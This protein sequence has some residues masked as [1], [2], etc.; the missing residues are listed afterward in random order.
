MTE[1]GGTIASGGAIDF[2]RYSRGLITSSNLHR[3]KALLGGALYLG[4]MANVRV[5]NSTIANNTAQFG[6]AASTVFSTLELSKTN[7]THNNSTWKHGTTLDIHSGL[8]VI[9]DCIFNDNEYVDG[10]IDIGCNGKAN[11]TGLIHLINNNINATSVGDLTQE[12]SYVNGTI[13]CNIKFKNDP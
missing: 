4:K 13:G 2:R 8:T 7:I 6:P 12:G 9:K 5:V 11:S 10:M 1:C 3:N